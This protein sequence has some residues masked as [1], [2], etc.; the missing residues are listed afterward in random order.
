MRLSSV[1][2]LSPALA[3]P[4]ALPLCPGCDYVHLYRAIDHALRNCRGPA[5]KD[6]LMH[7]N[8]PMFDWRC[9]RSRR[10]LARA[11]AGHDGTACPGR[12]D[13][14]CPVGTCSEE[15]AMEISADRIPLEAD[16]AE[17]AKASV[18]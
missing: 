17:A 8:C 14:I 13:E 16:T 12:P 4:T 18:A 10:G 1:G 7:G 9:G 3:G 11:V 15:A 6:D 5:P 2:I